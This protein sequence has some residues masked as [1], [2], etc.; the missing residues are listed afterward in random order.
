MRAGSPPRLSLRAPVAGLWQRGRH[1]LPARFDVIND[2]VAGAGRHFR[3]GDEGGGGA[4]SPPE[5][6]E[7]SLM[8]WPPPRLASYNQCSK[9]TTC[10]AGPLCR[11]RPP[12]FMTPRLCF[13]CSR[14][15][16]LAAS[17]MIASEN[18]TSAAVQQ[19]L[20]SCMTN[21]Y[22]EGQVG[23]RYYARQ[24][25][26]GRDEMESMCKIPELC[27]PLSGCPRQLRRCHTRWS[28][29]TGRI[30]GLDLPDGGQPQPRLPDAGQKVSATSPSIF[31]SMWTRR[32]GLI[33]YDAPGRPAAPPV[34]S[35]MLI[36]AG[37]SCYS[38]HLDYAP[39]SGPDL[40]RSRR[41][42][43]CRQAHVSG[44]GGAG[45]VAAPRPFEHSALSPP[46]R[47]KSSWR[48]P[49]LAAYLLPQRHGDAE[50]QRGARSPHESSASTRPSSPVLQGGPHNN[51][52]QR[53]L[54]AL[55]QC[56]SP[57]FNRLISSRRAAWPTEGARLLHRQLCGTVNHLCPSWTSGR[58]G[59]EGARALEK[60]LDPGALRPSGLRLRHSGADQRARLCE[61]DMRRVA[62]FIHRCGVRLRG[63]RR[64]NQAGR[65][66][67]RLAEHL[68]AA[69]LPR[70][71]SSGRAPRS[72]AP[73][74]APRQ[75]AKGL[76][77]AHGWPEF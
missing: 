69:V 63:H 25:G 7:A 32:H 60:S 44:L 41:P 9:E 62:D 26:R 3:P 27:R 20:A 12:A 47:T 46:P 53:W 59:V 52:M 30:M 74:G 2:A 4:A 40:R 6:A 64:P 54:F 67:P 43:S 56:M 36:V 71:P 23:N 77:H 57:D 49:A 39:P 29:R 8:K 75:F 5:S 18:F 38:Q 31:E 55:K 33:D 1:S 48:A 35:Q 65:T 10:F 17:I 68:S 76:R 22:S 70:T 21:K 61:A 45:G 50:R 14:P 37:M 58:R 72:C 19:A 66:R 16:L 42:S 73:P 24:R 15:G 34:P 11:A 28:G 51:A 13:P